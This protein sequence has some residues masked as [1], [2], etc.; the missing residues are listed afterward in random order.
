MLAIR[1]QRIGRTNDP[2][3]RITVQDHRRSPKRTRGLVEYVGSYDAR[4][5][6]PVINGERV[7]YW[8]SQGAKPSATVHNLLVDAK[9]IPGKKVNAHNKKTKPKKEE[10][11]EESKPAAAPAP[12][13][14]AAEEGQ[15]T[16]ETKTE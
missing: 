2:S 10:P 6:K 4:K 7:K 16:E 15:N 12:E 3:F 11:K 13:A 8:M 9:V 5:G 14:P 1:L